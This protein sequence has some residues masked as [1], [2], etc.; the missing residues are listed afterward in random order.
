MMSGHVEDSALMCGLM[1]GESKGRARRA[2][3]CVVGLD[4][5]EARVLK[6]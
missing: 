5:R 2:M 4:G 6:I 1:L 3:A